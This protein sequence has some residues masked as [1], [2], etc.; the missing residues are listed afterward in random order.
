MSGEGAGLEDEESR[1]PRERSNNIKGIEKSFR[2]NRTHN[3][4]R[5]AN[6]YIAELS[7]KFIQLYEALSQPSM[8]SIRRPA[9]I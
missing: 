2:R 9:S 8:S 1:D 7:E 5:V 4:G 6:H 3:L